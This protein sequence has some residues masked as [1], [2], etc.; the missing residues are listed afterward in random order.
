[1]NGAVLWA[2]LHILFW[3]SLTP[4]VTRW[5]G[6]NHFAAAPVALY[7]I[8]LFCAALAYYIL[9]RT[10]IAAQGDKSQLAMAVG[11]EIKGWVSTACYAVGVLSALFWTP[12][13]ALALYA[14]VGLM[15][16]VPDRR[17]ERTLG[18][19]N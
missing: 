2:N 15:W 6:E 13:V 17:I 9:E 19:R 12:W 11:A 8:V 1:V 16:L 10:L 3:L 7:G 14:F 4:F 5:M 18:A